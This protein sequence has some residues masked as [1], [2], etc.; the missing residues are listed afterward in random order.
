M[1]IEF[2]EPIALKSGERQLGKWLLARRIDCRQRWRCNR[3]YLRLAHDGSKICGQLYKHEVSAIVAA[4]ERCIHPPDV[5]QVMRLWEEI[6]RRG[7]IDPG[8][9]ALIDFE[10][11]EANS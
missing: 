5:P 1:E 4:F 8:R 11:R 3:F 7:E 2:F 10:V 6:T 9:A